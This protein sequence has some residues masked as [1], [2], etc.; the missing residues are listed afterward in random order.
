MH[1]MHNRDART[2]SVSQRCMLF[3][4]AGNNTLQ[5]SGSVIV[6][7]SHIVQLIAPRAHRQH[8]LHAARDRC[9]RVQSAPTHVL[10]QI[11]RDNATVQRRACNVQNTE[12]ASRETI[13][14]PTRG[15]SA[16]TENGTVINAFFSKCLRI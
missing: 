16:I 11:K 12:D 8:C 14:M 10:H 2:H 3:V 4:A 6:S 13:L 1:A 7:G 5:R 15:Q 9:T